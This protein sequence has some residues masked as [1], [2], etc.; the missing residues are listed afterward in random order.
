MTQA[1][2]YGVRLVLTFDDTS[3]QLAASSDAGS[4][5]V[6][7][8][9]A[10]STMSMAGASQAGQSWMERDF[11]TWLRTD[12]QFK[13]Y[14]L[15]TSGIFHSIFLD[16]SWL[17]VTETLE[18]KIAD[19]WGGLLYRYLSFVHF[20]IDLL[21]LCLSSLTFM[22]KLVKSVLLLW[23]CIWLLKL[24]AVNIL[25]PCLTLTSTKVAFFASVASST[26]LRK[27]QPFG[28]REKLLFITDSLI[29]SNQLCLL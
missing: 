9:M 1:L 27:M 2:W 24:L 21:N 14:A 3:G 5:A 25:D 12:T 13:T 6:T 15:F 26:S 11:I 29:N 7:K 22:S 18:I 17:W 19:K 4:S 8:W 10:G 20:C 16:H 28:R 23:D